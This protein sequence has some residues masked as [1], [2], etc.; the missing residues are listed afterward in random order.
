MIWAFDFLRFGL[1]GGLGGGIVD[2][3]DGDASTIVDG[4]SFDIS[5]ADISS[6]AMKDMLSSTS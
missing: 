6:S 3:T 4:S 5:F 1:L 2:V